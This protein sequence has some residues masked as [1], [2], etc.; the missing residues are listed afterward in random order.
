MRPLRWLRSLL[1]F[2][3]LPLLDLE[4]ERIDAAAAQHPYEVAFCVE[5]FYLT[6]ARE[7]RVWNNTRSVGALGVHHINAAVVA[8]V[9]REVITTVIVALIPWLQISGTLAGTYP[10]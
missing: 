8:V 10:S 4:R 7:E 3:L 9:S 5:P 2:S 6:A 1:R